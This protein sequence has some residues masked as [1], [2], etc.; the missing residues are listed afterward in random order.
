MLLLQEKGEL[1]SRKKKP[2]KAQTTKSVNFSWYNKLIMF[3]ALRKRS[4]QVRLLHMLIFQLC[5]RKSHVNIV[6]F[7][8]KLVTLFLTVG[9]SVS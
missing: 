1:M 5:W 6:V 9:V 7:A 4:L 3:F 2:A 8:S